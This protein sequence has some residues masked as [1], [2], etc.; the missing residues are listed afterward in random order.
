M[1]YVVAYDMPDTKRRTRLLKAMK[2]FGVHTQYSVFECE[3]DDHEHDKMLWTIQR[4]IDPTEDAI[5]VYRLCKE[6]V[7]SIL[8]QGIGKVSIEEDVVV[9]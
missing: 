1:F 7:R 4:I 6:C 2:G 3:L 5:K 8:V 9:I